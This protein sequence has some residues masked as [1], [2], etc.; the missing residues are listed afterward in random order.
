MVCLVICVS[1]YVSVERFFIVQK[2]P[3]ADGLYVEVRVVGI[4]NL[5]ANNLKRAANRPR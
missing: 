2:H 3:D 4:S 1:L 5:S